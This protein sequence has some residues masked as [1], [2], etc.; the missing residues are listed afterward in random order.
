MRQKLRNSTIKEN[1]QSI[2]E[3]RETVKNKINFIFE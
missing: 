2:E 3:V 1:V